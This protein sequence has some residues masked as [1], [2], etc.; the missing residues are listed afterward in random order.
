MLRYLADSGEVPLHV[1]MKMFW[2]DEEEPTA[3]RRTRD[4]VQQARKAGLVKLSPERELTTTVRLTAK[5]AATFEQR[6][7]PAMVGHPRA[8]GHHA[9]T[10][11]FVE[12]IK[13]GLGP[14]ERLVEGY[15]EPELR[16]KVQAGK[17]TQRGQVYDSFPDYVGV[18]ETMWADGSVTRRR[19]A[20]EY[21]TSKYTSKDI[22][23]KASSF[24][25]NYDEVR[26][27]ADSARTKAR[28]ER[29]VQKDCACLT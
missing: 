14:N 16:A 19:V 26:W 15:L 21:V 22:L 20:V 9:A 10:L 4:W 5:A 25:A 3:A 12:D 2:P 27:V 11:K 18:I 29:L 13:A 7:S 6:V 24:E 23:D 8:R 17:A 28:V 1:L